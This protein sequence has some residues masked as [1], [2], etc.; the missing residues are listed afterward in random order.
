MA[1]V[2]L[3]LNNIPIR[4]VVVATAVAAVLY[5]CH[6]VLDVAVAPDDVRPAVEAALPLIAAYFTRDPRV[7]K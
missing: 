1:L 2:N 3:L 6:H 5:V 4:K 7:S